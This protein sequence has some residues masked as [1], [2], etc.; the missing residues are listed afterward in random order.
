MADDRDLSFLDSTHEIYDKNL[1][2]WK[3]EER[4]LFGMDPATNELTR[5][6]EEEED[7]YT[8][9]LKEASYLNFPKRH[10]S[11]LA[12][13]LAKVAPLPNLGT[14]GT[15]IRS[16]KDSKKNPTLAELVYYNIDG[17]GVDGSQWPAWLFGIQERAIATG[18]R[19]CLVEMPHRA[20][21][22]ARPVTLADV[23]SGHRP[24]LVEWSPIHVPNWSF[25]DGRLDWAVIRLRL[26]PAG[27]KAW[28]P[29]PKQAG[30]YLLV[31]EGYDGLGAS[32]AGGGWWQFDH[33]KR[34]L[35]EG[36]WSRTG[37]AIP[38]VPLIAE[39]SAGTSEWPAMSRSLTMEL[40]QISVSLMNRISERDY[41]ASD[42]AKSLKFLL[43]VG[44]EEFNLAV[45]M[46]KEHAMMIP[47]PAQRD[48]EGRT[49][50]PQIYDSSSG[51]VAAEVFTTIINSKLAE[52][53]EIMVRQLTSGEN[54]SGVSRDKAFGEASSPLLTGLASRRETFEN[55]VIHF[56]EMRAGNA[57][58]D[59]YVTWPTEFEL[60]PVLEKIDRMLDRLAKM[61]MR[62]PTLEAE[63]IRRA[64]EHDGLLPP[65]AK[66]R[67][68]ILAEL[69]E[70]AR[71]AGVKVKADAMGV[72]V[73]PGQVDFT[74]AAA[75]AGFSEAD[76]ALMRAGAGNDTGDDDH[77]N[78]DD[79]DDDDDIGD[80]P[81]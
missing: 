73:G 71:A 46:L 33:E 8:A 59:G 56:L 2:A 74:T 29:L 63:L 78:D 25:T 6:K 65:D 79:E 80:P 61:A 9:R 35:G 23:K 37:G 53:H 18:H 81:V 49:V 77:G 24:Y 1:D 10:A 27:G 36:D 7:H 64:A 67:I 5:W 14:L 72:L 32:F 69:V 75:I 30:Y 21:D 22:D 54:T 20:E 62:S 12:G 31:R 42:A 58:P 51:A 41:D 3:R 34:P 43:A 48:A 55:T 11:T 70:S 76:V 57:S 60:A 66:Q 28:E 17:I 52:A 19:W 13:H 44:K 50:V 16:R 45:A 39:S 15:E 4:R 47:V 68:A 40:G 26:R 38:F